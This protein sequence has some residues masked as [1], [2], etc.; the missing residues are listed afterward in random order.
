MPG[1]LAIILI[2]P[3]VAHLLFAELVARRT[4]RRYQTDIDDQSSNL[5]LI[6]SDASNA[7]NV[8][9]VATDCSW[10]GWRKMVVASIHDES[11]DCRSFKLQPLD[12]GSLPRYLGGQS[13][14]VRIPAGGAA[15]SLSRFYS[16]SSGPGEDG[17][18]ITV[19]RVPNGRF[20]TQLHDAIDVGDV[21]EI[22]S[23]RGRFH[24]D[25]TAP[26]RPLH[27]IAAGI[28]ITPMLSMLLHSLEE[29]PSR[30]VHLYYQLRDET[31][32]PFLRALRFLNQSLEASSLFGLHVWFS[33]PT[34]NQMMKAGEFDGRITS[35]QIV[36]E[37]Q[38]GDLDCDYR[39]C[40]PVP[41]MESMAEGLIALGANPKR[42][43]YESFGGKLKS[44]GAI[45]VEQ[46]FDEQSISHHVKFCNGNTEAIYTDASSSLLELA[47][48]SSV[49]V[50]SSCRAG[51][52]GSCV[53]RLARGKIQYAQQPECEYGEDEVVLCMAQPTSDIEI[54][55]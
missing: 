30:E 6:N 22:Q 18:R 8:Q 53:H 48:T 7:R 20:S 3:I 27:L 33:R 29:T 44:P 1:T 55:V 26:D 10:K 38:R 36:T 11:P 16:L 28:G 41:F 25:A 54:D 37:L 14:Q 49:P 47:E 31:N 43:Q 19:R 13:I 21:L 42:V 50:V 12:E 51:I 39:I 32:A 15:G 23:P 45:S 40:G 46:N 35:E 2:V 17:Y 4:E 24:I 9:P 52:C 5:L 34:E